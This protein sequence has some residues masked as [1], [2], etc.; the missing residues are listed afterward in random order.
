M[1][2]IIYLEKV[3]SKIKWCKCVL[4]FCW[5]WCDFVFVLVS[6]VFGGYLRKVDVICVLVLFDK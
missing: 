5:Y 4:K 3:Y 2:F 1:I 6:V